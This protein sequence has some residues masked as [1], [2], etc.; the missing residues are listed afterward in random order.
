LKGWISVHP[1]ACVWITGFGFFEG[2]S[3]DFVA[4][5][6]FLFGLVFVFGDALDVTSVSRQKDVFFADET[7]APSA[8]VIGDTTGTSSTVPILRFAD[9]A[10][11]WTLFVSVADGWDVEAPSLQVVVV[12]LVSEEFSVAQSAD[13]GGFWKLASC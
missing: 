6:A 1:D 12:A 2:A 13:R 11:V 7:F 5:Y 10:T 9:V 4:W 3:F 8:H